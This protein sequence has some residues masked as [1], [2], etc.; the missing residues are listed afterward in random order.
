MTAR[1]ALVVAMAENRVI[2][3]DGGLPWRIPADLKHFKQLT[4]GKPIVMG[5]KTFD[6]IG[7]PLPGRPNIVVTRDRAK[8]WDGVEVAANVDS[9]LR[10]AEQH[11][12]RLGVDEI[13]LIGGAELYR[14]VLP[15]AARMYL[16]LVH[17]PAEGDTLFP[18]YDSAAWRE[19]AR[20]ERADIYRVPVSF[21]VL[22]RVGGGG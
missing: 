7:R 21:V 10:L 20:E 9:A 2:G 14:A 8:R 22:D 15:R 17:E 1:I 4:M 16:T 3:R 11:A 5:R 12:D 18:D 19:T 6:S 13:M